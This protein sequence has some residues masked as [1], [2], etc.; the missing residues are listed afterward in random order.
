MGKKMSLGSNGPERPD[1]S[2]SGEHLVYPIF[3]MMG[4]GT[5]FP[6]N[7]FITATS[8]FSSRF[9]GTSRQED[10][11]AFFSVVFNI[12][13]VTALACCVKYSWKQVVTPLAIYSLVFFATAILV[14]L[15][16]DHVSAHFLFY[17]TL[18]SLAVVGVCTALMSGGVFG[19][20]GMFPPNCTQALMSGQGLAG[21]IV[22]LT[23]ILTTL[24]AS[25]DDGCDNDSVDDGEPDCKRYV[26]DW[27][28]FSY[29]VI[30]CLILLGCIAGYIILDRLPITQ[31]YR[32][33]AA[34]ADTETTEEMDAPLLDSDEMD[35]EL[36]GQEGRVMKV[37][38]TLSIPAWSVFFIFNVTLAL[39]P[40]I[41]SKIESTQKCETSNR[42]FNDLFIPFG[43]LVFNGFDFLGRSLAGI[44]S[45]E[46]KTKLKRLVSIGSLLR[47]VFFPLFMLCNVSG[48]QL[49]VTFD[50]DFFPLIF[51]VVFA[52]SNGYISS[53][54]MMLGPQLVSPEDQELAGNVMIFFL[55]AGLMAGSAFSFVD[56]KIATDKW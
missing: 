22:S 17:Y 25:A 43:F 37:I 13:E 41:T 26:I 5:L 36:R 9:C 34:S 55:S 54:C 30:A 52:L 39:F 7:A 3:F 21:L 32:E 11:L 35:T 4:L 27:A 15:D 38:R 19:L 31:Y 14:L 24:G 12:T 20:A 45:I 6:W 51:M 29:F 8:Y 10:Y 23:S 47:V 40:T 16:D 44:Y 50:S 28:A 48:T 18:F 42:F 1:P 49:V 46:D 33:K 53:L 2:T 56:L